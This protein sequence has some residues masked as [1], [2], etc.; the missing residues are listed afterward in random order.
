MRVSGRGRATGTCG[1]VGAIA[2]AAA[3]AGACGGGSHVQPDAGAGAPGIDGG[4]PLYSLPDAA[5]AGLVGR[6]WGTLPSTA[7]DGGP[8]SADGASSAEGGV[9]AALD[10]AQASDGALTVSLWYSGTAYTGDIVS[11]PT[12]GRFDVVSFGS[13]TVSADGS[14][15]EVDKEADAMGPAVMVIL[16]RSRARL[17]HPGA[18]EV[19]PIA[20]SADGHLFSYAL[21]PD[22]TPWGWDSTRGKLF[23][24]AAGVDAG[25][26]ASDVDNIAEGA[27]AP[28]GSVVIY[29]V[30]RGLEPRVPIFAFDVATG[31]SQILTT[32]GAC[33]A[34]S[35][36]FSRDASRFAFSAGPSTSATTSITVWD[37][38]SHSAIAIPDSSNAFPYRFSATGRYWLYAGGGSTPL[39]TANSAFMPLYVYDFESQSAQSLGMARW[40][41]VSADGHYVAFERSDPKVVVWSESTGAITEFEAMSTGYTQPTMVSPDG[42]KVLYTDASGSVRVLVLGSSASAV[43]AS[44]VTCPGAVSTQAVG[45]SMFSAD[46]STVGALGHVASQCAQGLSPEAVDIFDIA[47]GMEQNLAL[48]AS[49]ATGSAGI[50]DVSSGEIVYDDVDPNF[51]HVWSPTLGNV[52]VSAGPNDGLSTLTALSYDGNRLLFALAQGLS[53]QPLTLWD[54][55][56]GA[57]TLS[58]F[59]NNP[60]PPFIAKLDPASSVALA[61]DAA[62]QGW[63]IAKPGSAPT[64]WVEGPNAHVASDSDLTYAVQGAAA[65]QDGVFVF[66]FSSGSSG[67]LEGGTAVAASD[68]H[69]YFVAADGLCEIGMR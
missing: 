29:C 56:A 36:V 17:V 38:A 22:N 12:G 30:R 24:M 60:I 49:T 46:S 64:A 42:Q 65:D 9:L 23:A 18:F 59:S 50:L 3:W 37:F 47:S 45:I 62:S 41:T 61:Y 48:P 66:S 35:M 10:V 25:Y 55:S 32:Q 57:T 34:G 11:A 19:T 40:I 15:I 53:P 21:T 8:A 13:V 4:A 69:V 2:V 54:R 31:V 39:D 1:W 51:V 27:V 44:A 43:V 68:T 33:S 16:K 6:W 63:V 28:D 58:M 67:F 52:S 20:F 5:V 7:V 26:P 14:T